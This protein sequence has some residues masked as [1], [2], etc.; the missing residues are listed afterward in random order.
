MSSQSAIIISGLAVFIALASA[1]FAALSWRVA[2]RANKRAEATEQRE[3]K[4]I[5]RR[6]KA[7]LTQLLGS[8]RAILYPLTA[9]HDSHIDT[10]AL[11]PDET[12]AAMRVQD[13]G[14]QTFKRTLDENR[15]HIDQALHEIPSYE[16]ENLPLLNLID[17][18]GMQEARLAE[19]RT[20]EASTRQLWEAVNEMVSAFNAE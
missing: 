17:I 15:D 8:Q 4:I 2:H 20:L 19:L 7:R 10:F 3:T 1:I 9:E 5:Y 6:E 12:Q 18:V 11:L 13:E 16:P 14:L